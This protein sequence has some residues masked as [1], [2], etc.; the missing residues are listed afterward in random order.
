MTWPPLKN[1]Q[2]DK[3]V[4]TGWDAQ[5]CIS[6]AEITPMQIH[7]CLRM[8]IMIMAGAAREKHAELYLQNIVLRF[9]L[10]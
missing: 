4:L 2:R 8:E 7:A 9:I 5:L 1:K 10:F 3:E 6:K